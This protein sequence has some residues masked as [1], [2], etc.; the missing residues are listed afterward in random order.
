MGWGLEELEAGFDGARV[1]VCR[2]LGLGSRNLEVLE[3][4]VPDALRPYLKEQL[5]KL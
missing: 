1:G 2:L 5:E 4:L 3:E